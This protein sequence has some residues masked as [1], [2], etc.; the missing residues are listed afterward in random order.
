M[1]TRVKVYPD[2]YLDSVLQLSGTRSMFEGGFF[3]VIVVRADSDLVDP[4]DLKGRTVATGAV[5][6][7]QATLLPLA[8]LA[9]DMPRLRS[10]V[11]DGSASALFLP[12]RFFR[13]DMVQDFER[14]GLSADDQE[15]LLLR[16][17]LQVDFLPVR[18][19]GIGVA[20]AEVV[21]RAFGGDA[22]G[23]ECLQAAQ[24][25]QDAVAR[26]VASMESIATAVNRAS[27]TVGQLGEFGQQIGRQDVPVWV[28]RAARTTAVSSW[29][30]VTN[31]SP[32]YEVEAGCPGCGSRASTIR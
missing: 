25:G 5:D 15:L 20:A 28:S 6:S 18:A 29:R 27:V 10:W 21:R 11:T 26:A 19:A 1:S 12:N 23:G 16:Q 17:R 32:S 30:T 13:T 31:P 4:V 24:A 22:G 14:G 8:V 3:R 2:T 7:P 9:P